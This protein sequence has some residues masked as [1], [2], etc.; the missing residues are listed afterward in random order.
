MAALHAPVDCARLLQ[1]KRRDLFQNLETVTSV[2]IEM[3][4]APFKKGDK[5]N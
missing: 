2:K 3:A 5:Q 4:D 1:E